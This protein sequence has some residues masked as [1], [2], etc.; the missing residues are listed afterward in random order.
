MSI[1]GILTSIAVSCAFAAYLF[2]ALVPVPSDMEQR[3]EVFWIFAKRK[4]VRALSV[5][6][7][8]FGLGHQIKVYRQLQATSIFS[9]VESADYTDVKV[10]ITEFDG[11]PVRVYY[12]SA[13][14]SKTPALIWI[15]GGGFVSGS[16]ESNDPQCTELARRLQ[17]PI[18]SINYR[19]APE[20]PYPV[21]FD[22]C[23]RATVYFLQHATEIDVDP[24]RV[25][26]A[27]SSAGG[28][29]A[30][31]VSL[32]LRDIGNF[33]RPLVQAL[34]VPCLQAIDFRTPSYQ[35][36]ANSA[37]L[38]THQMANYWFWYAR[39]MDGHKY[40]DVASENMHVSASAKQSELFHRVDHNLIPRKYISDDY[41]PDELQR[42]NE[43]LWDELE[44]VFADPYFAPLMAV[45][46]ADLPVTYIATAEHDILRDDGVLYARRLSAAGIEVNHKHYDHTYHELFRNLKYNDHAKMRLDDLINFLSSRL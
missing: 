23:V 26:I 5:A 36:N 14:G 11:V 12:P 41:M 16:A 43:E 30:A 31:A 19:M 8:Y 32:K 13:R 45:N 18:V 37:Y 38:P 20:F 40:A 2:Y 10:E 34:I 7:E 29:L 44:P 15:H 28:N 25:G 33:W 1:P 22:D 4:F 46:L 6:G 39:G 27:G 9:V 42:G 24:A 35:H 17:I 21:P 3:D